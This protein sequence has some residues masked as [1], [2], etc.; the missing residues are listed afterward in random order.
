MINGLYGLIMLVGLWSLSHI[1]FMRSQSKNTIY[2]YIL[3][4]NIAF[5]LFVAIPLITYITVP[6]IDRSV[7]ILQFHL[8]SSLFM[9]VIPIMVQKILQRTCYIPLWYGVSGLVITLFLLAW[10]IPSLMLIA[11]LIYSFIFLIFFMFFLYIRITSKVDHSIETLYLNRFFYSTIFFF[12]GILM[13]IT[14]VTEQYFNEFV[15]T[16]WFYLAIVSIVFSLPKTSKASAQPFDNQMLIQQF[17]LTQREAEIIPLI[18]DGKSNQE[19]ANELHI[20]LSTVKRHIY[21]IFQ[22]FNVSNRFELTQTINRS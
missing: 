8:I 22:K 21:H 19:I 14:G 10:F 1:V 7:I 15:C 17:G 16:P 5:W 2:H 12:P 13:D 20:S 4:T 6:T 9:I 11:K 3:P 18:L